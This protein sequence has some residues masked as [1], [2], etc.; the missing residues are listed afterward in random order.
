MRY[1]L[2]AST[3]QRTYYISFKK[4]FSPTFIIF[5]T[6][7]KF[8]L[9]SNRISPVLILS[10]YFFSFYLYFPRPRRFRRIC[11]FNSKSH[12]VLRSFNFGRGYLKRLLFKGSVPGY[13]PRP[14]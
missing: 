10:Y 8:F 5:K 14:W 9:N 6:L 3:Y 13:R 12:W 2:P 4:L 1:L 7:K 11:W